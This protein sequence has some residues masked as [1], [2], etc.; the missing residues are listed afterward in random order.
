MLKKLFTIITLASVLYAGRMTIVRDNFHHISYDP[1]V[2]DLTL[3]LVGEHSTET[4][5]YQRH[6]P[7]DLF[8]TGFMTPQPPAAVPGQRLD[9]N[10]L[11]LR[12]EFVEDEDTFTTGNGKMDLEGNGDFATD[13]L[14]YDPPHTRTYFERHMQF[15][16]N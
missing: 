12:V 11:V 6:R 10:V 15:L 4:V 16:S 1:P 8:G 9:M 13:G 5:R 3:Q 2:P 7:L 14:F